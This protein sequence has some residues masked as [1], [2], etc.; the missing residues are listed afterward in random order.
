VSEYIH[1]TR[2]DSLHAAL[3]VVPAFVLIAAGHLTVGVAFA[4]GLL[5]TS[6]MGIAPRRRLRL[7]YGIVGCLFGL[8]IL[9]GALIINA[10][11]IFATALLFFGI[12]FVATIL[13]SMRPVGT[14]LLG[15]LI[16][17]LGIGTGYGISKAAG[18][19]VAFMAGSVWSSLVMLPWPESPPDPQVRVRLAAMR[20]KHVKTYGVLLGLTAATAIFVGHFFDIP[21]PGWIATAALLVIRP[22]QDM[23][24]WRGVGRAVSTIAGTILVII[25]LSLS[26]THV[27]TALVSAVIAVLTI[28]ARTSKLYVTPFGTAFL[29]LT[30]ELYGVSNAASLGEVGRHRI[31]NNVLGALIALIYGLGVSWLLER[32][33]LRHPATTSSPQ[34]GS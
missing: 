9:L 32:T 11:D 15:I 5:P 10:H 2:E 7:V 30:I 31:I 13:A 27:E 14:L 23:T 4:I 25:A 33:V 28:G 19:M 29:I 12:C 17:S 1:L 26:L 6:L 18:L 22:V 16:P 20:P 21:Y 3:G 34:S 8:G 24:G